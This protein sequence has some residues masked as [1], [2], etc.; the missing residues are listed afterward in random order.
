MKELAYQRPREKLLERGAEALSTAELLQILIGSGYKGMPVARIAR[1]V[2][3]L[4]E[5][6]QDLS[7]NELLKV[8]GLGAVKAVQVIA[9]LELGARL[10]Y[11]VVAEPIEFLEIKTSAKRIIEYIT[12]DG[13]GKRMKHRTAIVNPEEHS[14]LVRS[15]FANALHDRAASIEVGIGSKSQQTKELDTELLRIVKMIFD[16]A[17]LL[18][19]RLN[20]VWVAN[21]TDQRPFPRKALS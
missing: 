13:S 11:P 20:N 4:V 21:E 8:R 5:K 2:A 7:Y 14:V 18:Q 10:A 12:L 6:S 3:E 19:I 9:V 17:S 1:A 16:T 15:I